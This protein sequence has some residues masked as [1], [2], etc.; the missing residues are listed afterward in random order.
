MTYTDGSCPNNRTV[1]PDNPAGWGFAAYVSNAPF[2]LHLEIASDWTLSYGKVK[3][4]PI[5]ASALVPLDGPNNTGEM[6]AVI[7]LLAV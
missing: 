3:T 1:G 4:M 2:S 6:K 7:E 5:D